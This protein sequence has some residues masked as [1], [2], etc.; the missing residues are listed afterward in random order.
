MQHRGVRLPKP[1]IHI[2]YST[3]FHNIYKF[4]LFSLDWL[5]GLIYVFLLPLIL[6]MPHL[7]IMHHRRQSWGFGGRDPPQ[8]GQGGRVVVYTW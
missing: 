4:P 6:A 7:R 1:M 2:A 3:Y 5:F 8:F